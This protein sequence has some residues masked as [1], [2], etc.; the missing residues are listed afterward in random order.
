MLLLI[1]TIDKAVIHEAHN[2]GEA[3]K[4][5]THASLEMLQYTGYP[6]WHIVETEV[7]KGSNECGQQ[8]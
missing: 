8:T 4:D 5:V 6:K 3:F 7:T 1:F 2:T